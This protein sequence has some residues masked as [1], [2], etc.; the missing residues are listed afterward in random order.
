MRTRKSC[1]SVRND[2]ARARCQRPREVCYRNQLRLVDPAGRTRVCGT[3]RTPELADPDPIAPRLGGT[4]TN[5]A[6]RAHPA[7]MVGV[8]TNKQQI[9]RSGLYACVQR[10]RSNLGDVTIHVVTY[11][12]TARDPG[13]CADPL[14]P[15]VGYDNPTFE[16]S[17]PA[18]CTSRSSR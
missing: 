11:V 4:P 17:R 1:R 5:G 15:A 14:S 6:E 8:A 9:S 12:A 18:E 3:L 10:R 7:Q 2:S 13:R 16:S